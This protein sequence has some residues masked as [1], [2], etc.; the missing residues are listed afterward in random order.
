MERKTLFGN[1]LL[2]SHNKAWKEPERGKALEF[3]KDDICKNLKTRW[4]RIK[5]IV[6]TIMSLQYLLFLQKN[7]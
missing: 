5:K 7:M 1:S 6:K 3:S 4:K 2:G